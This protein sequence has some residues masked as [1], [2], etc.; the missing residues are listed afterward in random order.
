MTSPELAKEFTIM[1]KAFQHEGAAARFNAD[2]I[3]SYEDMAGP[4]AVCT[5]KDAV[6]SKGAWWM[7][8]HEVH[9]GT[10]EG[11]YVHGDQFVV[12]FTYDVT[13]KE[14]GE[15]RNLDE[16]GLYTIR[17]GKIAEERFFYLQT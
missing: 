1:L 9:S 17:D 14:T 16:V 15:R 2:D 12:H 6:K 13:V 10:V 8:N 4:M 11:P 3:V 7:A 5:G